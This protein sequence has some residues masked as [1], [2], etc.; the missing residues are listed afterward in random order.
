MTDLA[1]I[2]PLYEILGDDWR[3]ADVMWLFEPD[4]KARLLIEEDSH[5]LGALVTAITS[6]ARAMMTRCLAWNRYRLGEMQHFY[7]ARQ[8][9]NVGKV[10]RQQLDALFATPPQPDEPASPR[11]IVAGPVY[12]Y[13]LLTFCGVAWREP[14]VDH[15]PGHYCKD[16]AYLG[17]CYEIVT[18]RNGLALC[19]IILEDD[20]IPETVLQVQEVSYGTD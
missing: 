12:H 9:A 18:K 16:C 10:N 2:R 1:N 3:S 13:P 19:E 7:T 5:Q 17:E 8:I 11:V 20:P 14:V 6:V 4:I 15:N